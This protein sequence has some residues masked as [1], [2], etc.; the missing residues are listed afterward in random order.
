[1]MTTHEGRTY[2]LNRGSVE[3]LVND[4]RTYSITKS[5]HLNEQ[6]GDVLDLMKREIMNT[7]GI[8]HENNFYFN[9]ESYE[10]EE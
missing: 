6:I 3:D 8:L 9:V 1:M 4:L 5:S 7:Y 10:K 2:I